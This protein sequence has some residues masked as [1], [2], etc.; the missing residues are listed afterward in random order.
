MTS[1][2]T[3]WDFKKNKHIRDDGCYEWFPSRH[4]WQ[5]ERSFGTKS[6]ETGNTE[7]FRCDTSLRIAIQKTCKRTHTLRH[8][9]I[10]T[11]PLP[12]HILDIHRFERKPS[13]ST[14][15]F[16]PTLGSSLILGRRVAIWSI[17]N[18]A[19]PLE[20]D[21]KIHPQFGPGDCLLKTMDFWYFK[22]PRKI[23]SM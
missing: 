15:I 10:K 23:S 1:D 21:L 9:P 2:Q 8:F 11:F 4:D 12:Q 16:D 20:G 6:H 19:I 17:R 7:W 22:C 3:S 18:C 13:V 5:M 14:T